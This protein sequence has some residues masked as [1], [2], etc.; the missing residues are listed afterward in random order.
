MIVVLISSM[1]E[2]LLFDQLVEHARH[3]TVEA[4]LNQ[5]GLVAAGHTSG[6]EASDAHWHESRFCRQV[7]LAVKC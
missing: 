3:G 6:V 4:S 2:R 1:E 5:R 7:T